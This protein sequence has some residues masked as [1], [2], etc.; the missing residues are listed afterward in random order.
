MVGVDSNVALARRAAQTAP[1]VVARL[2][3]LDWLGDGVLGGACAVL[4]VEHIA[5]PGILFAAVRRAVRPGGALVMVANHPLFTAEGAAPITDLADGEVLWRWGEYFTPGPVP[6]VIGG[7]TVT[8]HHRTMGELL[9]VAAA[10]GWAVEE[11]VE[12]PLAPTTIARMAGYEGQEGFP[13]LV[14]IR[15]R[16]AGDG[17][18]GGAQI[19]TADP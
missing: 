6:T 13:R 16:A 19:G 15:W 4:M 5:E 10:A 17:S 11:L 9:T 2:P 8:F 7:V 12:R 3:T 14:G 18:G 1:V